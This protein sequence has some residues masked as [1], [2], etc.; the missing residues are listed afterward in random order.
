[1]NP[2]AAP[3]QSSNG[4]KG[5]QEVVE[6]LADPATHGGAKVEHITTHISHVFIAGP[7]TYKLKR[8]VARNFVDYSTLEKRKALCERE[9]AININNAPQIYKAVLPII[10]TPEGL[11]LGGTGEPI[12]YV[13]AMQTF[14]ATDTFDAMADNGELTS[15][16]I[17]DLAD[18]IAR[19]HE[20]AE[21]TDQF[22]GS[23]AVRQTIDELVATI[24]ATPHAPS[25][26][27]P[28]AQWKRAVL[29]EL[30]R[31]EWQIDARRRHGFVRRCHGDMHLANICL[32][33]GRPALFDAIEFSDKIASID[34]LY[35]IAF[36][37]MDLLRRGFRDHATLLLSRYLSLSRDYSGLKLL[38]LFI[39]MRAAVRAMVAAAN[40]GP[41]G[42]RDARARLEFASLCLAA[43]PA[44]RLIAIG[45]L[46]GTGK[47]TLAKLL[48]PDIPGLIGA[49]SIR[50]DVC[51]K[52]LFNVA[53][54]QP[55][56]KNAYT[57]DIS[58]QVYRVMMSD[59][60]RALL[61]STSVILD[62]TFLDGAEVA[63]LER[64]AKETGAEF[65]GLRLSADLQ[66]SKNRIMQRSGD[67][68]DATPQ[69]AEQQWLIATD[70]PS[71]IKLD[72]SGTPGEVAAKAR[73]ALA[74]GNS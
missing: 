33:D 54:E 7:N 61:A 43:Q 20:R 67:A 48:A 29:D 34:I 18:A 39:S 42:T 58:G 17:Q 32:Y 72:A 3:P 44:P 73:K 52:R 24:E 15:H 5:Q 41:D 9:L 69:I 6:F 63:R 37:T 51:R 26:Q 36:T 30:R 55:L 70:N 23:Q 53:P 21:R 27:A 50:S 13:V 38:A 64:L 22:G 49:L 46:S 66:L 71:W 59:A 28:L 25:L 16:H 47:S 35:D 57:A 60:R 65:A 68:S 14:K 45:G 1:M 40:D 62:A 2:K 10:R 31:H 12:D 11:R 74:I 56:P 8:A 4:E 19:Q